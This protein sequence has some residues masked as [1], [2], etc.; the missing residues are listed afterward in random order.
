MKQIMDKFRLKKTVFFVYALKNQKDHLCT[1]LD[2]VEKKFFAAGDI[3][4]DFTAFVIFSTNRII[5]FGSKS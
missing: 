1:Q 2:N 4:R 5:V 3:G